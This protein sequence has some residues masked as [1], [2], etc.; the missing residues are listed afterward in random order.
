MR[1]FLNALTA[2]LIAELHTVA[3]QGRADFPSTIAFKGNYL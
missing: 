2:L 1:N 3:S